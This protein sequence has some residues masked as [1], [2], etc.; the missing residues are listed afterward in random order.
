MAFAGKIAPGLPSAMF[1]HGNKVRSPLFHRGRASPAEVCRVVSDAAALSNGT[2]GAYSPERGVAI[3]LGLGA[4]GFV[5]YNLQNWVSTTYANMNTF[6]AVWAPQPGLFIAGGDSSPYLQYSRDGAAWNNGTSAVNGVRALVWAKEF[7]RVVAVG[8]T[9]PF[10]QWSTDGLIWTAGAGTAAQI[11][12]AYSSRR[13]RLVALANG[14]TAGMISDDGGATW[15]AVTSQFSVINMIYVDTLDLFVAFDSAVS[16]KIQW[17]RDGIIW[18][19]RQVLPASGVNEALVWNPTT[20]QIVGVNDGGGSIL[21]ST[22]ALNWKTRAVPSAQSAVTSRAS[23]FF[24]PGRNQAVFPRNTQI[25]RL[26]M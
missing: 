7:G 24:A 22:D 5:S 19:S 17:S 16:G 10:A 3:A 9:S 1:S 18:K 12:L 4:V 25:Y 26:V 23:G 8:N 21:I 6:G 11:A 14:S 20:K 2:A 13:R 15:K